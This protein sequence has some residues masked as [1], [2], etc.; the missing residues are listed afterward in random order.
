MYSRHNDLVSELKFLLNTYL[1]VQIYT[2]ESSCLAGKNQS[3]SPFAQILGSPSL[4]NIMVFESFLYHVILCV[5]AEKSTCLYL[6][7]GHFRTTG[8]PCSS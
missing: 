1:L 3:A 7:E 2:P 8:S 4:P 6:G 5:K